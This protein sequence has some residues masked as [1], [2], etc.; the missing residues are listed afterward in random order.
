MNE[1]DFI[2]VGAGSAGCLL[3]NRLSANPKNKV[4]LLEAGGKDK[5]PNISIPAAFN[6][7]FQSK[8]DWNYHTVPQPHMGNRPMYQPRGKVLGGSSS[9]NAMIYIRGHRSDY[10]GWEAL[11]N[12]GWNYD[13]VLPYFKKFEQNLRIQDAYHGNDGELKISDPCEP[14]ILT[15]TLFQAAQQAGYQLNDDFNGAV[16]DGF[17][18]YQLTQC[19]GKRCSAANAFLETARHRPNLAVVTNALVQKILI[20][21]STAKGVSYEHGGKLV[22]ASA[23]NAVILT[24]GAFNSPHLLMLSGLGDESTLR[25]FGIEVKKHLPGVGKNLQ[26]HLLGGVLYH[27]KQNITLDAAERLPNVFGNLW[28]YLV[29]KKGPFTSNVA[30]GGG[31]VRTLPDLAAPDMQFHFAPAYYV[32]HG[33]KNPKT[34]NGFGIGATLITPYSQGE[35]RLASANPH[36][37]PLIDPNYFSDE[38]DIQ[39]MLRGSQIAATILQQPAFDAYRGNI[40]IPD[41]EDIPENEMIEYLR[42]YSE[43]LYHPVGTCKMGN[44]AM[45]VVDEQLQV[46]GI[47]RLR[48]ADASIMP[49]I[50]RGN[51]NAPAMMIAEKAAS[52]LLE[53]Q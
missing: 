26:D 9:I 48:V 3:A 52:F 20:E 45:A 8:Y 46:H 37:L 35:V 11:G 27:C 34:G 10:D 12:R 5:H 40:F 38:R 50:V 33:F 13:A 42:E 25:S 14:H 17:G 19:D 1:F 24:A 6:K 30:E 18:F 23:G 7:L 15:K 4:L 39:T 31:F 43:T 16:Q 44:D 51:T 28:K 21:N 41:R 36:D 2:I 53:Q 32:Q 47:E 22:T 29:Y 49:M